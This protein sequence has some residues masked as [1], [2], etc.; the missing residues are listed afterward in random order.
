MGEKNKYDIKPKNKKNRKFL[1][2][3]YNT[4]KD[5][6]LLI[7]EVIFENINFEP[8]TS[9]NAKVWKEDNGVSYDV[10]ADPDFSF[11]IYQDRSLTPLV[12]LIDVN[13]MSIIKMSSGFDDNLFDALV[14]SKI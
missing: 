1:E 5:D 10:V 4:Y 11:E 7:L 8:A 12:M 2:E 3:F 6:G 13:D 9:E 14:R